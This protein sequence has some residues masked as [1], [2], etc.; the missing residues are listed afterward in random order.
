MDRKRASPL[1]SL[2]EVDSRAAR[3]AEWRSSKAAP[4]AAGARTSMEIS[5]E[6][7][8]RS[9]SKLRRVALA[10]LLCVGLPRVGWAD[11]SASLPQQE[12]TWGGVD[13]VNPQA[14][15][16][17]FPDS[18][19][20]V[21][22]VS[23]ADLDGDGYP[24]LLFITH[25][26]SDFT[27]NGVLR[28]VHGGGPSKGE[29]YF[30]LCGTTLWQEGQDPNSVSCT[31]ASAVLDP[32]A[33]VA[34]GDL[35]GDGD[36]EIVALTETDDIQILSHD[37]SIESTYDATWPY[38][39][40]MPTIANVDHRGYA[41]IVVGK[42]LF[43]LEHDAGG[44]VAVLDAF[45]ASN[46][47][48]TASL[49]KI[50]CLADL[51][52]APGLEI[53]VGAKVYRWPS[54]PPGVTRRSD[55]SG[56]ETDPDQVAWCNGQLLVVWDGITLNGLPNQDGFCAVA[57]VLGAVPLD[58]TGPANPPDGQPEVIVVANGQLWILDG[59]T[60][61]LQRQIT[62]SGTRG[63]APVV[64]DFD[65]DGYPEIAAAFATRYQVFDL[66]A[67]S[68][69][70]PA[71]P[72]TPSND[73]TSV[74]SVNAARTPPVPGSPCT[75]DAACSALDA[76][77]TC[78]EQT[79]ACVCLHNGWSR[80][81]EDDSSQATGSSAFDLDGDG[82]AE[83][84][85]RDECRWR[86]YSGLDGFVWFREPV[87][88]RT[89]A[90]GPAVADTDGDGVA[91]VAFTTDNEAGFCSEGFT[92]LNDG[93]EV[94]GHA[95]WSPARAIWSQ[96]AQ[97][98]T[99]V[100][101]DGSVP[102]FEAKSWLRLLDRSPSNTYRAGQPG[103][104]LALYEDPTYTNVQGEVAT[105]ESHLAALGRGVRTFTG[106]TGADWA[107]GLVDMEAL[108][109]PLLTSGTLIE[110]LDPGA[111]A[112]AHAFVAAGGGL[113]QHQGF[114]SS[115]PGAA[116]FLNGVFGFSLAEDGGGSA[117]VLDAAG[118]TGT[119]FAPG[120]A[121]LAAVNDLDNLQGSS[122]PPGGHVIYGFGAQ[123]ETVALMPYDSGKIAY[124]GL[125]WLDG[126]D[127]DW[128]TV[129]GLALEE[130]AVTP[131]P[132]PRFAYGFAVGAAA[133]GALWARR[134]RA[135]RRRDPSA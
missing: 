66:Q 109:V 89:R 31:C 43:T 28:A 30:A 120:P 94:W 29:G 83:L 85:Y 132:E 129:L 61:Q 5:S 54:P 79:G 126:G 51:T 53:V 74:A 102:P 118:A 12:L 127:D 7:A 39:V 37:G 77:S 9:P 113:V 40:P 19:Q 14:V 62:G 32:S 111:R 114:V 4:R 50:S 11:L 95:N 6:Y 116:N 106:T 123:S 135:P 130:V 107:A 15:G 108:V 82:A 115:T 80:L 26:A 47:P 45:A 125:D 128:H 58:P 78:N 63:G 65:G 69:S 131:I 96:F 56:S 134:N 117:S 60:G 38:N 44:H 91:E 49:G 17:A 20:S 41:E 81:T 8:G 36:V 72:T 121:S 48:P 75:S 88:S 122:L 110:G 23:V 103:P 18:A 10:A 22:P 70:C 68:G 27:S 25:C 119:A 98:G 24:E 42:H 105:L 35:D 16:S 46:L 90:E 3:S 92:N 76:S 71:W 64:A 112:Q 104:T 57:D 21:S 67:P 133:L 2:V 101:A 99:D 33:S 84:F 93:L 55:C 87:T 97:H 124:L 59:A 86:M 52:A 13:A 34:V 73:A 1:P 100:A